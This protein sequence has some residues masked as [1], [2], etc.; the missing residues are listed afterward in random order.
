MLR[1]SLLFATVAV[2][3]FARSVEIRHAMAPDPVPVPFHFNSKG[4]T[5]A[6]FV[7][8]KK[9]NYIVTVAFTPGVSHAKV[10]S[11]HLAIGWTIIN[12]QSSPFVI[13]DWNS[14]SWPNRYDLVRFTSKPGTKYTVA[15]TVPLSNPDLQQLDPRLRVLV[16]PSDRHRD[17]VRSINYFLLAHFLLLVSLGF[18]GGSFWGSPRSPRP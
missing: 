11:A 13:G 3:A 4:E 15:A 9:T 7:A 2:G 14:S 12:D 16:S 1:V 10:A 6:S 8:E 18:L 5:R 17:I